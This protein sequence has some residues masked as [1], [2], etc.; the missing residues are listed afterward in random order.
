MIDLNNQMFANAFPPGF[1]QFQMGNPMLQAQRQAA[2]SMLS[3]QFGAFRQ[4]FGMAGPA[5]A[6][7]QLFQFMGGFGPMG[8]ALAPFAGTLAQNIL[9]TNLSN[10]APFGQT[11]DPGRFILGGMGSRPAMPFRS[12]IDTSTQFQN[13]NPEQALDQIQKREDEDRLFRSIN[14]VTSGFTDF[15]NAGDQGRI[16][17]ARTAADVT[18]F[19]R[20]G[21]PLARLA[22]GLLESLG[23]EDELAVVPS[24]TNTANQFLGRARFNRTFGRELSTDLIDRV[25]DIGSPLSEVGFRGSGQALEQLASRNMLDIGRANLSGAV[26]RNQLDELKKRAVEQVEDIGEILQAGKEI[27]LTIDQTLT[28]FQAFTG[29]DLQGRLQRAED[30]AIRNFG[31]T[32]FTGTMDEAVREARQQTAEVTAREFREA[33]ISAELAGSDLPT[34]LAISAAG[35]GQLEQMGISGAQSA[36]LDEVTALTAQAQGTGVTQSQIAQMAAGR[37]GTF[38]RTREGRAAAVLMNAVQTGMVDENDPQIRALMDQ[39]QSTGRIDAGQVNAALSDAGLGRDTITNLFTSQGVQNALSNPEVLESMTEA[40]TFDERFNFTGTVRRQIGRR[41]RSGV[42]ARVSEEMQNL[43]LDP[44]ALQDIIIQGI[45]NGDLTE[46]L[47]QFAADNNLD[48][49]QLLQFGAVME[50]QVD[51]IARADSRVQ[52]AAATLKRED[53]ERAR[54]AREAASTQLAFQDVVTELARQ[55]QT[56]KVLKNMGMDEE[57]ANDQKALNE[58]IAEQEKEAESLKEQAKELRKEGKI[59]E[60]KALEAE[61][62]KLRTGAERLRDLQSGIPVDQQNILERFGEAFRNVGAGGAGLEDLASLQN[63]VSQMFGGMDR[64]EVARLVVDQL[65]IVEDGKVTGLNM[66]GL[67]RFGLD[68]EGVDQD[69]LLDFVR[70]FESDLTKTVQTAEEEEE[71]KKTPEQLEEEAAKE[72]EQL[73]LEEQEAA[74]EEQQNFGDRLQETLN[75]LITQ[76][77][78]LLDRALI[79]VNISSS[80]IPLVED[81][82]PEDGSQ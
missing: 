32:S 64:Q 42:G 13:A 76:L 19:L 4:P 8:M 69:I 26:N 37:V 11:F 66:E 29:G 5:T 74:N 12:Q 18:N 33:Q 52:N 43:G 36:L 61:E 59:E 17:A 49:D 45:M 40:M 51:Q 20:S 2:F 50:N 81:Q 67:K 78:E 6:Q 15:Q 23:V 9:G 48:R 39:F 62:L 70:S 82:V 30:K 24:V 75:E 10:V 38:V 80:D 65:G 72:E 60:A 3:P 1:Q 58:A 56:R 41:M 21:D 46:Q 68:K 63:V 25:N 22:S 47:S 77:N 35:A 71:G 31:R 16:D 7:T 28:A 73:K 57:L 79:N 34:L 55:T 54:A 53:P 44:N 14:A 27:G